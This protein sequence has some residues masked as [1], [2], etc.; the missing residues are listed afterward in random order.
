MER[1]PKIKTI[2]PVSH[3]QSWF[4]VFAPTR[5][6][7]DELFSLSSGGSSF[8]F[9]AEGE[10]I[11]GSLIYRVISWALLDYSDADSSDGDG[12]TRP[13]EAVGQVI[14]GTIVNET[15][16]MGEEDGV[17]VL[18]GYFETKEECHAALIEEVFG[19]PDED[20]DDDDEDD[21]EDDED[22]DDDEDDDEVGRAD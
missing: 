4:A 16:N 19:P 1:P 22:E 20:D 17:E 10:A 8:P 14:C 18:L 12:G 5:M 15:S 7:E 11:I 13:D 21:D 3:G 6:K 9:G 2:I